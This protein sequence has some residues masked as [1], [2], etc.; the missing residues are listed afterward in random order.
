MSV[1]DLLQI[2]GI[3]SSDTESRIDDFREGSR[4]YGS[5]DF[6][7]SFGEFWSNTKRP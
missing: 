4:R 5:G 1:E 6:A 3:R 2:L 7:A